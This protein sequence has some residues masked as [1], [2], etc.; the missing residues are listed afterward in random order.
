[1]K[2][3]RLV[4]IV[5]CATLVAACAED[6]VESAPAE[7]SR[8]A[9]ARTGG[10]RTASR[11]SQERSAWGGQEAEKRQA[12]STERSARGQGEQRDATAASGRLAGG[13]AAAGGGRSAEGRQGAG[14]RGAQAGGRQ[15]AG[16]RGAQAGG[17]RGAG[18]RAAMMRR[19][20]N[21]PVP[22]AV[23]TVHRGRVDAYY[24][25]TTSLS[26]EEEAVVVARTTGVVEKIFVEE[27][28]L[29][30]AGDPLAQLDTR[31]L[32]LE[33]ARTETNIRSLDRAF[34]RSR[35]LMK[36]KMISPDAFDQAQF[37][38]EREEATLALQQYELEEATVRAP[39]VG[40]I[41]VRHIKVGNTLSPNNEAFE[42]KS[43]DTIEAVLNVPEKELAKMQVGQFARVRVDA[44]ESDYFEGVV[45][46]IAPEVD[47]T[48]GTFRVTVA[49]VNAR[50]LLKPGMFARVNVRYDSSDNA[51]LVSREALVIQK[52]E[53][54]VFVVRDGL[55]TRQEVTTGYSMDGNIE[56]KEGLTEGD[57]VV[58]TG[59]G[60]LRDGASVRVVTL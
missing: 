13:G 59:Q 9:G 6:G 39:I 31:R 52:D 47:A 45:D 51:L 5:L 15:G 12:G 27:G 57:E 55:A 49:L 36:T 4:S 20:Q 25:T 35:Q 8:E 18:D 60:G 46:R 16:G 21:R 28:D 17:R 32:R 34:E 37:E 14:G 41:T 38:L 23:S 53:R 43:A 44:L 19:F 50:D 7:N 33:V 56:I 2:E 30:A 42:I 3:W 11:G 22:V 58:I 54:S 1:M 48:T 29:V 40:R 26:A 10:E 24:N